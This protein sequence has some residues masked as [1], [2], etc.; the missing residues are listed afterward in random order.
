MHT[1]AICLHSS[2]EV[3]SCSVRKYVGWDVE[4]GRRSEAWKVYVSDME[5]ACRS[6]PGEGVHIISTI[7]SREMAHS[8]CVCV[9]LV[10]VSQC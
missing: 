9:C 2:S 7:R 8:A 3:C 4:A 6:G 10:F 5:T 1:P